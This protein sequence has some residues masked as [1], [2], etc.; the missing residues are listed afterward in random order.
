MTDFCLRAGMGRVTD[1]G[2]DTGEKALH[3]VIRISIYIS[4]GVAHF[5]KPSFDGFKSGLAERF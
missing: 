4:P 5:L 1:R 2:P 3:R